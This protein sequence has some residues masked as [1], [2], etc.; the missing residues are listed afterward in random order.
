MKEKKKKQ[1]ASDQTEPAAAPEEPALKKPKTAV[2]PTPSG[3]AKAKVQVKKPRKPP[4]KSKK[5]KIAVKKDGKTKP[6]PNVMKRPSVKSPKVPT[7]SAK[8]KL[9]PVHV[10]CEGEEEVKEHDPPIEGVVTR[11]RAKPLELA[12]EPI[13]K[14]KDESQPKE[15]NQPDQHTQPSQPEKKEPMPCVPP[16]QEGAKTAHTDSQETAWSLGG[17][18]CI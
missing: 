3:T 13:T 10:E 7:G 15:S 1:K 14:L 9:E 12:V 17:R 2:K 6:K 5:P 16:S 18:I 4:A 11:I 8:D